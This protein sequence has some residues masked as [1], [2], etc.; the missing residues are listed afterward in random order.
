VFIVLGLGKIAFAVSSTTVFIVEG[1]LKNIRRRHRAEKDID[2]GR[3]LRIWIQPAGR[4]RPDRR[5]GCSYLTS[6]DQSLYDDFG[7][8]T[9]AG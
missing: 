3:D 5:R 8:G 4:W 9:K 7:S 6:S 2:K 1:K